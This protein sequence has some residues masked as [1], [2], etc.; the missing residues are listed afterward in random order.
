MPSAKY[1]HLS[2]LCVWVLGL[3]SIC[4][5]DYQIRIHGDKITSLGMEEQVW[6]ASHIVLGLVAITLLIAA[7]KETQKT[8]TKALLVAANIF[9]A[10]VS[11]IVII[12][13]Y[14][15][16]TGIDSL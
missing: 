9:V 15:L 2:A 1:L 8:Y 12:G 6:F 13:W 14:V 11:Y 5:I 4:L 10:A 16:G 7:L 3:L